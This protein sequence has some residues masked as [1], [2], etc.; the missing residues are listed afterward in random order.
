MIN[1]LVCNH[2]IDE[3]TNFC[4]VC[5]EYQKTKRIVVIKES[6]NVL[7]ILCILTFI[8]SLFTIVRA[9]FYQ[10]MSDIGFADQ[11]Y[12]RGWIYAASSIGTIVGAI[13]MLMY[14]KLNGLYIYSAFQILKSRK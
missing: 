14:R 3:E 1:C 9:L 6:S 7:T 10:S 2:Q 4:P 8:G 11:E 5:G 13:V 12:Y